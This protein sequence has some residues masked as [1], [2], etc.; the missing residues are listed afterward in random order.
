M[1]EINLLREEKQTT[2]VG[3]TLDQNKRVLGMF[4]GGIAVL[5]LVLLVWWWRLSARESS[6][7]QQIIDAEAKKKEMEEIIKAVKVFEAKKI[8]LEKKLELIDSLKK[9]QMGPSTLLTELKDMLPE[10]LW[11]ASLIERDLHLT[12]NGGAASY[13]A[14]A[15]F[16]ANLD[17]SAYFS[18]VDLKNAE[19]KDGKYR[20]SLSCDFT[21]SPQS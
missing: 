13:N 5:I 15:N 14:V 19:E 21:P 1:I 18:N 10:S 2:K 17:K 6:L 11:L 12:I 16:Y 8:I 7:K 3:L 20:F 4:L 9:N